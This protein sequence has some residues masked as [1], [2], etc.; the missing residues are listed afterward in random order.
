MFAYA[1][2]DVQF[3]DKRAR[4]VEDPAAPPTYIATPKSAGK[5]L[6]Q[7]IDEPVK[8][9]NRTL[10]LRKWTDSNTNRLVY[11]VSIV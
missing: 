4:A 9:G 5:R 3:M 6:N 8:G 1:A 2:P 7:H 10:M 11:Q